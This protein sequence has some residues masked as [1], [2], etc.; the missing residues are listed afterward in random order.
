MS[1]QKRISIVDLDSIIQTAIEGFKFIDS[2]N[3][4]KIS[5]YVPAV[6]F[7]RFKRPARS[8]HTPSVKTKFFDRLASKVKNDLYEDRRHNKHIAVTTASDYL[9]KVRKAVA[10]ECNPK[11]PTL[12]AELR[13]LKNKYPDYSKQFNSINIA[14]ADNVVYIKSRSLSEIDTDSLQ[15]LNA[16]NDLD[17][18]TVLHPFLGQLH[19]DKARKAKRT[20]GIELALEYR[21]QNVITVPYSNIEKVINDGL[22]SENFY[23][24]V[25]AVALATGRRA[26]EVIHTGTFSKSNG[27]KNVAFKGVV[28]KKSAVKKRKSHVI[29]LNIE[30]ERVIKAVAKLRATTRYL[31]M[32][33]GFDQLTPLERNK[34][35]NSKISKTL[36]EKVKKLI[37]NIKDFKSTRTIA[38]NVSLE[39]I[40]KVKP[41]Y[42]SLDVDAFLKQYFLHDS[43]SESIHYKHVKVDFNAKFQ[44]MDK[45]STKVGEIVSNPDLSAFELI[46]GELSSSIVKGMKTIAKF[47]RVLI[48]TLQNNGGFVISKSILRKGKH[49]D[50]GVIK[51]KGGQ[52]GG[53]KWIGLEVVQVAIEK[54]HKDNGLSGKV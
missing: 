23:D 20:D 16:Y 39:L 1:K 38:G 4:K 44:V 50:K 49:T 10:L 46:D 51:F 42:K 54:Y 40:H 11:H 36:N 15:G 27:S 24:L 28:K 13:A 47:H 48:E 21:K 53:Q 6:G 3:V 14:T 25:I 5:E 19:L 18:L 2:W 17:A 37:P 7:V 43:F 30:S 52:S 8:A 35:V 45:T 12:S 26:V 32:V 41:A 22:E 34:V 9:G 31:E 29:P 33:A